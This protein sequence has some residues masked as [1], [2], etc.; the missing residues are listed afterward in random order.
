MSFL[1]F[2][3]A[4]GVGIFTT[5]G[6]LSFSLQVALLR[7]SKL[8]GSLSSVVNNELSCFILPLLL[9]ILLFVQIYVVS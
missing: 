2:W 6:L 5:W 9:S 1:S 3:L 8:V 7:F 4:T